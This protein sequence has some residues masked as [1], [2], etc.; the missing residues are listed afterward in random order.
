MKLYYTILFL[1]IIFSN[2]LLPGEWT[3]VDYYKDYSDYGVSYSCI[4]CINEDTCISFGHESFFNIRERH[5][6]DGGKTWVTGLEINGFHDSS[7]RYHNSPRMWDVVFLNNNFCIAI[8]DSGWTYRSTDGLK[9]WEKDSLPEFEHGASFINMHDENFGVTGSRNFYITLDGA[10]N[11]QSYDFNKCIELPDSMIFFGTQ[12]ACISQDGKAIKVLAVDSIGVD[13][14][15]EYIISSSD[16][17]KT[18]E[19]YP[20]TPQRL[21][22]LYFFDEL[23]GFGCG[24][25]KTSLYSTTARSCIYYTSDGG[26]SWEARLDTLFVPKYKLQKLDFVTEDTAYAYGSKNNVWLSTDAG[27]TWNMMDSLKSKAWEHINDHIDRYC[28]LKN[29]VIYGCYW[30]Y[31]AI[32][33]WEGKPVGVESAAPPEQEAILYPNPVSRGG[34][35][36]IRLLHD[37]FAKISISILSADGRTVEK[38]YTAEL[39]PGMNKFEYKNCSLTP[40]AYILRIYNPGNFVIHEKFIVE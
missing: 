1:V 22:Y 4:D 36:N 5:T 21:S 30:M 29:E 28:F 33:K 3:T 7:G 35:L 16:T 26:K 18:W 40:G 9:T 2:S 8:G 13:Q 17:G 10:R 24:G 12:E 19:V 27:M 6:F 37:R 25:D 20:H 39:L 31:G 23:H 15:H 32:V 34:K 38:P 14:W 11:W